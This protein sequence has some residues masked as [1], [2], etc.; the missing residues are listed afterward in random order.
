MLRKPLPPGGF[1]MATPNEL[2]HQTDRVDLAISGMSCASCAARV[3]KAL[4]GVEGVDDCTVNFATE[5]ATVHYDP[6][7]VAP[8]AMRSA[9]ADLGYSASEPL[10]HTMAPAAHD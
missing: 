3:E 4:A 1:A 6:T 5:T 9:V 2:T 7:R 10:Q 8:P